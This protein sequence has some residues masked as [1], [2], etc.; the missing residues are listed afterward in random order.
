MGSKGEWREKERGKGTGQEGRKR[1]GMRCG[2]PPP[3]F[4]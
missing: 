2:V 4:E 3:T 1:V